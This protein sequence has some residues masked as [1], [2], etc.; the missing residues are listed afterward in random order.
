MREGAG[1]EGRWGSGEVGSVGVSEGAAGGRGKQTEEKS[2]YD[3]MVWYD[4]VRYNTV[5]VS[6]GGE[7]LRSCGGL[8]AGDGKGVVGG[9]VCVCPPPCAAARTRNPR[10]ASTIPCT[11]L[12]NVPGSFIPCTTLPAV[13]GP[14]QRRTPTVY[15]SKNAFL[16]AAPMW[17]SLS[18]SSA[19]ASISSSDGFST[20][21]RP[22]LGL[23]RHTP[24]SSAP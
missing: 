19:S 17:L 7:E 1:G 2:G 22:S 4:M 23:S 14:S 8:W 20:I 11:I 6:P 15:L 18:S 16:A 3:G 24:I 13:S 10:S 21:F 5:W 12:S 9:C